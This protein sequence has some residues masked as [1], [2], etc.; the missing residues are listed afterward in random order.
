MKSL[1]DEVNSSQSDAVFE[2]ES[3]V[4]TG[5]WIIDVEISATI[6][7]TNVQCSELNKPNKSEPL[8]HSHM[9]VKGTLL[10]LALLT[11]PQPKPYT[12]GKLRQESD[13]CFSE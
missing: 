2:F 8:F 9:W 12:I 5:R 10:Y 1:V 6:A 4:E 3:K 13:L 7:A 11:T